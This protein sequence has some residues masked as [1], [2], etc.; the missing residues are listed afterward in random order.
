MGS[1][2]RLTRNPF[3]KLNQAELYWSSKT[4]VLLRGIAFPNSMSSRSDGIHRAR[5]TKMAMGSRGIEPRS[6]PLEG[7]VIPLHYDPNN[8]RDWLL[9]CNTNFEQKNI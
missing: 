6:V 1:R 8:I 7:T 5:Q 4:C 3:Q 9:L 2:G